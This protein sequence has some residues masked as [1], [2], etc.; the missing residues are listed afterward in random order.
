MF[1]IEDISPLIELE[2]TEFDILN[3]LWP[4]NGKITLLSACRSLFYAKACRFSKEFII[5]FGAGVD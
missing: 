3:T 1:H 5:I 4:T 2:A